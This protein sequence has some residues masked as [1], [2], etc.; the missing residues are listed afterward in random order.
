MDKTMNLC[1]SYFRFLASTPSHND[2]DHSYDLSTS[3][4]LPESKHGLRSKA[5]VLELAMG[6]LILYIFNLDYPVIDSYNDKDELLDVVDLER[7]KVRG[8]FG[9]PFHGIYREKF[10]YGLQNNKLL[11]NWRDSWIKYGLVKQYGGFNSAIKALERF[12]FIW[13]SDMSGF[14]RRVCLDK[15]YEI[16]N[17][18][19]IVP[20]GLDYSDL[21]AT[22]T[23]DN[24]RP[25]V[26]LPNGYVVQRATGN[27]SGKNN[28][29]TD[30]SIAHFIMLIYILVKKLMSIGVEP[31]LSYIFENATIMIYSDD[32]LGGMFLE[33]FGF[34]DPQDFLDWEREC[35]SEFN[36][37]CK[38][39]AQLHT[40]KS[41]GARVDSQHSFLGS[42]CHYDEST[43]MYIPY[44]RLGK[45]CST[46]TQKYGT[47]DKE[48]R[49]ARVLNLTLNCYP[50]PE[51]FEQAL[52]YLKWLY[53]KDP[54]MGYKY[55][56]IL[57]EFEIDYSVRETFRRIY[58]GFE[59]RFRK[60]QFAHL[61][62]GLFT[63][64]TP[65]TFK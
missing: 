47:K 40:V 50:N 29:T 34:E 35:Y 42:F 13:E 63:F 56:E 43:A 8:V 39:S 38:K 27:D 32:K 12:P 9:A 41:V 52:S 21:I 10:L 19:L 58:M 54:E 46:L 20:P 53:A 3:P 31:K 65:C 4:G 44:P 61:A 30:N 49:F 5:K 7:N 1:H 16:R 33:K 2:E 62:W 25:T 15:V 57:N 24:T 17:K 64:F 55:D 28:T 37:E 11:A 6:L 48:V 26:L 22:V 14:D 51:L 60:Q 36:M 18:N 45:I 23:R 59:A